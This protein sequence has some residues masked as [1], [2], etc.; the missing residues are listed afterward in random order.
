MTNL[1]LF[2]SDSRF[3]LGCSGALD[4]ASGSEDSAPHLNRKQNQRR[5]NT[6][7]YP[8]PGPLWGSIRGRWI[9]KF[10]AAPK[11]ET[12]SEANRHH[13]I[14]LSAGALWGPRRG[15]WIGRFCA[16]LEREAKSE[17]SRHH[18]IP[19]CWVGLGPCMRQVDRKI[20]RRIWT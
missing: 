3:L 16:A 14:Y 18:P 10:C 19:S 6:S 4:V 2:N 15:K 1:F 9:G 17:A 8:P 7:P 20:S 5:S 11:Q 13:P 12:K